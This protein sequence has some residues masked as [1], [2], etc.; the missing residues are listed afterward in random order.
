[1]KLAIT[2]QSIIV[3]TLFSSYS[4][5]EEVPREVPSNSL[6]VEYQKQGQ[7]ITETSLI[8]LDT[9]YQIPSKTYQYLDEIFTSFYHQI[10][11]NTTIADSTF[12]SSAHY[13]LISIPIVAEN[14]HGLKIEFFGN[15]SEPTSRGLSNLSN[16]QA[17]S[18]HYSNTQ[19]LNIYDSELSIGAGIS[20]KSGQNSKIKVIITNNEIPGYGNSN[21]LLGFE[22][23]F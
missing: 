15:F 5:A 10:T 19:F 21:A 18:N 9:V 12:K 2:L 11:F 16:D 23:K 7:K 22:T 8:S 3:T 20:F 17:L 13:E 1:M 4:Y 6:Q 14:K